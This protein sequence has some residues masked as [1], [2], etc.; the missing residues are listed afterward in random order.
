MSA[1]KE[2]K[3]YWIKWYAIVIGFL[4]LQIIFYYYVTQIFNH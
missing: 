4:L 3:Q 1:N 2:N